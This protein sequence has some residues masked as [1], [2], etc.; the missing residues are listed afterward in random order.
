MSKLH[1]LRAIDL[2]FVDLLLG[3]Q[4][5]E[6]DARSG[7]VVAVDEAC[8]GGDEIFQRSDI[9]RIAFLDHQ[10]HLAGHE[11]DHAIL[12]RIEPLPAGL[13]ALRAK[14]AARVAAVVR[15]LRWKGP[16]FAVSALAREGLD[17]LLHATFG[18]VSARR[19]PVV[20]PDQRFD[21]PTEGDGHV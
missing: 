8:P 17:P 9:Q 7:I 21:A 20:V 3:Q 5:V 12:S 11:G 16:V 19:N 15:R 4:L 1:L 6:Q 14:F 2:R 10:A 18:H 13:D